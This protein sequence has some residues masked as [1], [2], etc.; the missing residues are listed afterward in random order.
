MFGVPGFR[1][2]PAATFAPTQHALA[3]KAAVGLA[4]LTEQSSH[5]L[6]VPE[7]LMNYV[8]TVNS[9]AQKAELTRKIL[10]RYIIGT[11]VHRIDPVYVPYYPETNNTYTV[12]VNDPS[13][14]RDQ[15]LPYDLNAPLANIGNLTTASFKKPIYTAGIGAP[16]CMMM[17]LIFRKS[18]I[19]EFI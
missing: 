5:E 1:V 7:N 11:D 6:R 3:G 15:H 9:V 17:P 16:G 13:V 18:D 12:P 4:Q 2:D 19:N 8:K 14:S 10:E